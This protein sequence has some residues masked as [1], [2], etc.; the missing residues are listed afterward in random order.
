MNKIE[1]SFFLMHINIFM[2]SKRAVINALDFAAGNGFADDT[3]ALQQALAG[4]NKTLLIP[5]GAYIISTAIRVFSNTR[6]VAAP[7]AV[8]RLAAGAG[9]KLEDWLIC[10]ANP[11]KGNSNIEIEG[12]VW[13]AN[14]RTNP[15]GDEHAPGAFSGVAVNFTNVHDL[16]LKNMTVCNPD[17]F[18]IRLGDVDDFRVE[19]IKLFNL[20]TRINQD[21]VHLGGG[22]RRGLIKKIH[23]ISP[24]TP[25]DDMVALNADDD[26]TRHFNRGM[27]CG[28]IEDIVIEDLYADSAYTFIRMLS[29]DNPIKNIKASNLR[30]GVRVNLLNLN[31]WRFPRGKGAISNVTVRNVAI[32]KMPAHNTFPESIETLALCDIGLKVENF[33]I[34][35][36]VRLP[37]DCARAP[38]F[39]IDNDCRN[40]LKLNGITTSQFNQ[41]RET[42]P[43]GSWKDI[44]GGIAAAKIDKISL[45][46]GGFKYLGLNCR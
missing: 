4:G 1:K 13:D 41:L 32:R 39:S 17:S 6:I 26:V 35:N 8:I 3:S 23:A 16:T 9:K 5:D 10:N 40:N 12:G 36:F 38:T 44:K 21:G 27:R 46:A 37:S 43:A 15:R 42:M 29:Q 7:N 45:A 20:F 19:N 24:F 11:G 34:E 31:R 22:C 25:N 14:C 33:V 18:F 2:R 30:G 28:P